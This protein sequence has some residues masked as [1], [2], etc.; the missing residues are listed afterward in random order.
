MLLFTFFYFL[1]VRAAILKSIS[2]YMSLRGHH[3]WPMRKPSV[4]SGNY[5]TAAETEQQMPHPLNG[6]NVNKWVN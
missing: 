6:H 4:F 1:K 2:V 3:D 5:P